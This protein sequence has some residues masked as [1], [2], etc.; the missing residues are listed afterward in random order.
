MVGWS[1][2]DC[3]FGRFVLVINCKLKSYFYLTPYRFKAILTRGRCSTST[4]TH[5]HTHTHAFE[6]GKDIWALRVSCAFMFAPQIMLANVKMWWWWWC[7][8]TLEAAVASAPFLFCP[9]C[10]FK[11]TF[12]I[13]YT[14]LSNH[15]CLLSSRPSCLAYR[16]FSAVLHFRI[17]HIL[18][19]A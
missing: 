10:I 1:F 5:T 16:L 17:R 3:V 6:R 18:L 2:V 4:Q 8:C 9:E 12:Q 11:F 14:N 7:R 13:S 19:N 15:I